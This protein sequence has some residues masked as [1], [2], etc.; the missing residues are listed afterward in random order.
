M[1]SEQSFT[2]LM[3]VSTI[4]VAI[5]AILLS[6]TSGV[7]RDIS[8]YEPSIRYIRYLTTFIA[9]RLIIHLITT[10]YR[11]FAKFHIYSQKSDFYIKFDISLRD[12]ADI[13]I[14]TILVILLFLLVVQFGIIE[15]PARKSR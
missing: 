8:L 7:G 12:L 3:G 6:L 15:E 4:Y 2:I 10:Y 1:S 13:A 14:G 5:F 11:A 9:I